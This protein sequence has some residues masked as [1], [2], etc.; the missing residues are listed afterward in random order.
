M[1]LM[2]TLKSGEPEL[3]PSRGFLPLFPVHRIPLQ[4]PEC[5]DGKRKASKDLRLPSSLS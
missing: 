5:E 1:S 2:K 3:P 4:T